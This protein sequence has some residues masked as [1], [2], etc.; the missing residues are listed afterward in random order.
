LTPELRFHSSLVIPSFKGFFFSAIG[1]AFVQLFSVS[2]PLE[3]VL[4][5]TPIFF[6]SLSGWFT[7]VLLCFC[8]ED[9]SVSSAL[10]V[11][12][13]NFPFGCATRPDHPAWPFPLHPDSPFCLFSWA[14]LFLR[15]DDRGVFAR[16]GPGRHIFLI[17]RD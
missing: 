1:P 10:G 14:F 8:S 13:Q 15:A 5:G 16:N 17:D 2:S 4:H 7:I 11:F 12:V 3:A 6:F 9:G